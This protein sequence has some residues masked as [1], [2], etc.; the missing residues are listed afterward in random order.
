MRSFLRLSRKLRVWSFISLTLIFFLGL[1]VNAIE[2]NLDDPESIKQAASTIAWD[3]VHYYTGN[4]TG[5]V[6]GNL[7]DP[8]YWWEAGA[9]FGSLVQYWAY[10]GD[11]SYNDITMQALLHQAGPTGDF[12]PENQTRTEGNDDQGFWA[13]S[14]MT[15]AERNF[16]NPP[17]DKPQWLA[18]AQ[19][20][21]NQQASRWDNQTCGGGLHWQIFAFNNGYTYRN[22]IANGCF[23]NIAARLARY[24]GNATYAEWAAK[25]WDWVQSVGLIGPKYEVFDGTD[26]KGNCT[27]LNHIE[28]TYNNGVFLHGAAHMYNY[29]NGSAEWKTRVDGLLA[30]QS[31]FYLKNIMYE[32][33]CELINDCQTDQFSFKAYLARWMGEVMQIAPYTYDTIMAKL[34]PTAQAAAAQCVGGKRG[35]S[36]GMKW[37]TGTYDGTDGVGQQM[38]ALEVIQAS[39]AP[40]VSGPVTTVT[41][42]SKGNAAAGTGDQA[43][44]DPTVL[45]PVTSGDRVG[46]AILTTAI[47]SGI[48]SC[49]YI[50]IA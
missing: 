23:F 25:T 38:S 19:A 14:A 35:S 32:V 16:P 42:T 34:R 8:Y 2:L 24:T 41:G 27:S 15:A 12:M 43:T 40:L 13:F 20:V 17:K 29:T 37:T 4:N 31:I 21:F 30:S 36:C 10:T 3:M 7:P 46:A 5:D 1:K 6:P 28:W 26:E 18:M 47:L 48:F 22:S 50:M 44:K 9:M 45:K 11:S 39:L 33:A 49:S